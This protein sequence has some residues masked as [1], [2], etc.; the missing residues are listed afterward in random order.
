MADR[1]MFSKRIV[2]SA[3][4]LKMPVSSRELY[5]QLGIEADDDGIV[6]AFNTMRITGATE[7]DLKVLASKGFVQVLNED[8]VTYILDWNENNKLRADR[9]VDSIYKNLLL[10]MNPEAQLIEPKPRADTGKITGRPMDGIGKDRLVEVKVVEG[11][12][13]EEKKEEKKPYFAN[14]ELNSIFTEFIE[15]RKKLKA[16][17]S[18]RAIKTLINKLN[19]Y[20]DDT[21]YQMIENSIVNSWK[22]VYE[23]KEQKAIGY[24]QKPIREEIVPDWFNKKVEKEEATPEE[25]A[26]MEELLRE[27]KEP[28][29]YKPNPELQQRLKEKYGKKQ[30]V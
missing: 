8:L 2:R 21:K 27:F 26:E 10:Q 15:V 9:K 14:A 17:N 13:I 11:K 23:L 29:E 30:N 4:F 20:D 7:D 28:Q 5:W 24:K 6:E 22:D 1:R 18:E 3:K 12:V 19:K 16:V 25:I